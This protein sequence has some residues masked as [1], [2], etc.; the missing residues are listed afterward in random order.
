MILCVIYICMYILAHVSTL[1][2]A[3][4]WLLCRTWEMGLE[5]VL[6]FPPLSS[7]VQFSLPKPV[8][9]SWLGLP[10]HE[11]HALT[12]A[13]LDQIQP[14]SGARSPSYG[15]WCV[16]GGATHWCCC[17]ILSSRISCWGQPGC[18]AAFSGCS[19]RASPLTCLNVRKPVMKALSEQPSI[20]GAESQDKQVSF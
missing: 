14:L 7:V 12:T 10:A 3:F 2:S 11:A 13:L 6:V 5:E 15:R 4:T 18:S 9:L 8:W 19:P 16:T 20:A 1:R 17:G